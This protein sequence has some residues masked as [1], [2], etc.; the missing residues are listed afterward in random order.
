MLHTIKIVIHSGLC[1]AEH[2]WCSYLY[3]HLAIIGL[4][5]GTSALVLDLYF[6]SRWFIY[7]F[8]NIPFGE[9]LK[10]KSQSHRKELRENI[11]NHVHKSSLIEDLA[12]LIDFHLH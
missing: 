9:R 1:S 10:F 6:N 3:D 7:V 8:W 2:L 12:V 5:T 4:E 11:T